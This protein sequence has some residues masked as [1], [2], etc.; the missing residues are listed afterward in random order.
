MK[1]K[2]KKICLE[3]GK[4]FMAFEKRITCSGN[5]Y[6]NLKRKEWNLKHSKKINCLYCNDEF[7]Q[8]K[9][10]QKFCSSICTQK[11]NNEKWYKEHGTERYSI[12]KDNKDYKDKAKAQYHANMAIK[13]S[14]ACLFCGNEK[15]DMHHNDYT[16]PLEVIFVCRSC[17]N[18]IHRN[19]FI[20]KLK[21]E[22]NE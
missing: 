20:I 10:T 16:K 22:S 4:D 5:C 17:H 12:N 11:Y 13:K 14:K 15:V 6:N 8:Q 1:E 2:I 21:E 19:G 9:P 3:C 18:K 7:M